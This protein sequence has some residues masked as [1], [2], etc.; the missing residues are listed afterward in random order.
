MDQILNLNKAMEI[1]D[2]DASLYKELMSDFLKQYPK[3]MNEI[4]KDIK[5]KNSKDLLFHA[6]RIK[7]M[8][9]HLGADKASNIAQNLE[10]SSRMDDYK[11]LDMLSRQLNRELVNLKIF[12]KK[13]INFTS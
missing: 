2:N 4:V 8:L 3:Y 7:G 1:F 12:F 6:H 9:Q 13:N 11:N 5:N 10:K